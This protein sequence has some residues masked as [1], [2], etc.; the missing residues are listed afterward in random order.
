MAY[1]PYS[2]PWFHP[3]LKHTKLQPAHGWICS[4]TAARRGFIRTGAVATKDMCVS[5]PFAPIRKTHEGC[6]YGLVTDNNIAVAQRSDVIFLA[7]KP[8][9]IPAVLAEIGAAVVARCACVVSIAAGVSLGSLEAALPGGA[10]VVRVMP[11]LPALVSQSAAGF[12]LGT[13]AT[14]KDSE[15]VR[16]LLSTVGCAEEVPEKLMDAVT[17]LSG[18]GPA[19]GFLMVEALADGGVRAGLPRPIAQNLAAQTLKGAAEM[20]LKTGKHPGLLKDQVCSPGGTTIAGVEA[21]ENSGFRA[22][23]ISAVTAAAKRSAELRIAAEEAQMKPKS[24]L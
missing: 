7:V 9:V 10:K 12:C 16:M 24:R 5:E 21:L 1:H 17:G 2:S 19:F 23:A 18:S 14:K 13:H 4:N 11:N 15:R 22:S 20:V 3:S 8:D 6:G